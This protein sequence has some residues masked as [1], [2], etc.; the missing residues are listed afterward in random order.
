MSRATEISLGGNLRMTLARSGNQPMIG[1]YR[2]TGHGVKRRE[3]WIAVT[4]ANDLQLIRRTNQPTATFWVGST[5]FEVPN[6]EV[7]RVAEFYG[8]TP[9]GPKS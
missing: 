3:A 5:K 6:A 1:V 8:I 2:R 9:S 4:I 7:D